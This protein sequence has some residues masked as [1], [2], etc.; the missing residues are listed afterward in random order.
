MKSEKATSLLMAITDDVEAMHIAVLCIPTKQELKI[1]S[2]DIKGFLMS[3]INF[4]VF[5]F[6]GQK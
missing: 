5:A 4:L 6:H 2:A 1:P 3:T